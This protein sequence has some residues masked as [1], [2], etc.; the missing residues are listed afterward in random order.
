MKKKQK[1][2]PKTI[3][4]NSVNHSNPCQVVTITHLPSYQLC[5]FETP[6]IISPRDTKLWGYNMPYLRV[7]VELNVT[8]R[9]SSNA[10]GCLLIVLQVE[11]LNESFHLPRRV[12]QVSAPFVHDPHLR[13]KYESKVQVQFVEFPLH[14]VVLPS[15]FLY[16]HR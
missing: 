2:Q 14:I 11:S 9:Y 3:H 6:S 1:L 12:E 4:L 5:L 7:I 13:W 8:T 10:G 16:L 15:L